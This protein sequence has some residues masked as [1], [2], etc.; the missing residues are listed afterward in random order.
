[1]PP[2]AALFTSGRPHNKAPNKTQIGPHYIENPLEAGGIEPPAPVTGNRSGDLETP[3]STDP[4]KRVA[5]RVA[6]DR[7]IDP[8]LAAVVDAWATLPAAVRAGIVAMV[9]AA[10]Q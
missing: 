7:Q 1:M 10:G 2:S 9:R 8:E 3:I 6:P 4:A 5:P